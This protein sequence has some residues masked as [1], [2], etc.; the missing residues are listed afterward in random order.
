MSKKKEVKAKVEK[1]AK[2]AGKP[3]KEAGKP[4]KEAGKP[5]EGE[6]PDYVKNK[7]WL[8][9]YPKDVAHEVTIPNDKS[10]VDMFDEAVAKNPD[11]VSLIFFGREIPRKYL[12]DQVDRLA[13]AFQQKLGI[14][15]GD[16]VAIYLLNS[17]QFQIAYFGA[18][19]AG[20][21][22][23]C[24]SPLFVPR[25]V[26]YQINDSGAQ[27]LILIDAFWKN[28]EAIQKEVK[29]KNII[30]V[31]LAGQP[32]P[33]PEDKAKGIY[34]MANLIKDTEPKVTKVKIDPMKDVA[35]IQYTGGTTGL[36]K[37]AMLTHNNLISNAYE[38]SVPT[39]ALRK[40][41][42]QPYIK[43]ISVMPW[44][45]IYGQTC[46]VV[47][48]QIVDGQYVLFPTFDVAAI[49]DAINKYKPWMLLGVAA[50]LI[51]L[52]NNPKTKDTDFS[53]LKYMSMGGASTPEAV[54]QQWKKISGNPISE[55]FGLTE[56]S[57]V[58]HT[59]P[60]ELFG[61]RAGS[62]GPPIP[63]TLVGVVNPESNKFLPIGELGEMVISG[64]QVM[65]GY[66]N[67]PEETKK[68]FFEAGGLKWL[69][70]GDLCTM[71]KDGYF[72][73]MD[74]TKDIVKYKGHSVYPREI[75]EVLF[76]NPAVLD[77]GVIGIPDPE[78]GENIKAYIVLR[79]EYKGKTTEND[80]IEWCKK[81][82]AAYKYPRYV[83]FVDSLPKTNTGKVLK[84]VL[85][86]QD[87]AKKKKK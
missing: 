75:E 76:T 7:I 11:F 38:I 60:V 32:I 82:M 68:V 26:A 63:D 50:M 61:E 55:G 59:R 51:G 67:R 9:S 56:A 37:G 8:K 6:L 19:K 35:V 78:A 29:L 13:T 80:I 70:T 72:F 49:C 23:T 22:L 14:K 47:T 41:W 16:K 77:V 83:E 43:A 64:P 25:E 27:T 4:A 71:D 54:V 17:P 34:H 33:V 74:R 79:P 28:Y 52:M 24:I 48:A 30:L 5:K 86:E 44:Y 42:K 66:Y 58:T 45:H 46:E 81:N 2:E 36:P 53:S 20:A 18:L 84:R 15:K 87:A 10:L 12:K 65:L 40:R 3:A 31:N 73:I 57:P 62:V 85:R 1:P 69:K 39:D 21:T